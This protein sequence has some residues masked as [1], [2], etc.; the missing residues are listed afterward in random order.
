M[1]PVHLPQTSSSIHGCL[2]ILIT[3][4]TTEDAVLLYLVLDHVLLVAIDPSRR[5]SRAAPAK[6]EVGSHPIL[7][8]PTTHRGG[9]HSPAEYSEISTGL[10]VSFDQN[11]WEVKTMLFTSRQTILPPAP[12]P[13]R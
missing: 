5:G 12:A 9:V 3:W 8:C 1:I 7:P 10:F 4:S 2:S 13:P 11:A 6:G